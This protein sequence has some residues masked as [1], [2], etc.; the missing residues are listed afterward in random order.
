[1]KPVVAASKDKPRVEAKYEG[2]LIKCPWDPTCYA[3]LD[4]EDGDEAYDLR[5]HLFALGV[6]PDL[7]RQRWRDLKRQR[8]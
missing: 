1:M 4:R 2:N 3:R 5:L 6:D 8:K 7:H